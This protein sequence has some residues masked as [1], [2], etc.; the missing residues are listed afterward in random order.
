MS[1][2]NTAKIGKGFVEGLIVYALINGGVNTGE[3]LASG[4]ETP[5]AYARG[6][7]IDNALDLGNGML[8]VAR[9]IIDLFDGNEE[10]AGQAESLPVSIS[11]QAGVYPI[12]QSGA[13]LS[14]AGAE[15][16]DVL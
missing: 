6:L 15:L 14:L 1:R 13:V 11:E 16:P 12:T 8:S 9:G 10:V 4:Y 5:A 7:T 3:R 2:V